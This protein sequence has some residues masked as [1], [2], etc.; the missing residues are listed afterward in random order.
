LTAQ[1]LKISEE[2]LRDH[3]WKYLGYRAFAR[4][5]ASSKAFLIIRQFSTL[6]ARVLLALQDDISL[7]EEQLDLLERSYSRP[8]PED[9]D[10]GSFRRDTHIERKVLM[11]KIQVALEKYSKITGPHCI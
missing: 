4:W 2:E 6:N 7:L 3:P 1:H 8:G 10:N 9:D 5:A 11:E